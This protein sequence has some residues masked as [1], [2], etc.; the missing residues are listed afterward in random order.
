MPERGRKDI[1]V[2][3][4]GV[5]FLRGKL[6]QKRRRVLLRYRYYDGKNSVKNFSRL[7]PKEYRWMSAS[8]GWCAKGVDALAG[9]IVFNRFRN[10]DFNLNYI[11]AINNPDVLFS[12]AILAALIGSCSFISISRGEDGAPR[13]QVIDGS[14]A[15]G[16][17]DELTGMLHEGYAVLERDTYG[18]PT[19]EAYYTPAAT[20]FYRAGKYE[21]HQT[22]PAPYPLLVPI[23]FRPDATRPFGHSRITRSCMDHVQSALRTM[24]RAEV[25][26]EFY[27][28]PQRYVLGLDDPTAFDAEKAKMSDFLRFGTGKSGNTPMAGQFPQESMAPFVDSYR[29]EA[30][31]FAGE[32]DLTVHDLGV[33]MDN[34]ASYEAMQGSHELL[35]I[36]ATNARGP[37]G[38]GF[39]NA[40][41]L[42]ACVRDGV[43]YNRDAIRSTVPAWRPVF[44]PDVGQ[45]GAVGDAL[46][47]INEAVPGYL[48]PEKI[49]DILGF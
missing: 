6:A 48:T 2:D 24:I 20:V 38:T 7:I 31:R 37:F 14:N 30:A 19:I 35:K 28:W 44:P 5:D 47:K 9:R 45:L 15:T 33:P 46:Y 10:D 4:Y 36:T 16:I 29:M 25:S 27:A 17:A 40:G 18:N 21:A 43:A 8:L 26:E 23:V 41:Y 42:A 1:A 49:E 3:L 22:N 34:P 13:L 12:S 39:L 11:F 32:V